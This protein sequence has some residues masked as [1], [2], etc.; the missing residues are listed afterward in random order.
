MD[1]GPS[2]APW[3]TRCSTASAWL[4]NDMSITAAGWPWPAARL[5]T[6]PEAS[7]FRRRSPSVVLR[8]ERQHLARRAGGGARQRARGRSRRR[9]GPA[10]AS[11]A[12][13]F[14]RAKCAAREHV[15]GARHGDE[16]VAALGGHERGHHLEALHPRLERA[17]RVDLADDHL[18]AGAAGAQRD[19]LAGPA[20]AEHDDRLA[21]QQQVRRAQDAVERRLAGAVV[22]VEQ[23]LGARLVDRD[24]R[25]GEAAL[26]L[27]R[28]QPHQAGRRLLRAA[29]QPASS[30]RPRRVEHGEQVG[31]VVERDVRR[32]VDHRD[33]ARRVGVGVLAAAAVRRAAV[34]DAAPRR[35]RPAWS[36]GWRRRARPPPR[37]R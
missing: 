23:P 20:V 19:A 21:R 29:D 35:P 3:R 25:A 14:M 34:G 31:A 15:A 11:T 36:A 26:G 4:A 17:H 9:S 10:L 8:D 28:A 13:S 37:R 30:S 12:P 32:A 24:D 22:V 27:E 33:D 7:R 6:R 18:R 16:H 2:A 5:T 1:A